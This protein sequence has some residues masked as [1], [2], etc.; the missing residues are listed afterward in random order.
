MQVP[1]EALE[2]L[3]RRLTSVSAN[4]DTP[5]V[6]FLAK[7]MPIFF[8]NFGMTLVKKLVVG[9]CMYYIVL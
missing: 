8:V 7:V 2:F 6:P 5:Y 4:L 9:S 1:R 3:K